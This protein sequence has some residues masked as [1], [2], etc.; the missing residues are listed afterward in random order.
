MLSPINL[1]DYYYFFGQEEVEIISCIIIY[2]GK[3]SH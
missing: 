2:G 3:I 1:L